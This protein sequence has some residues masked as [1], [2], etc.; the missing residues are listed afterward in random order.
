MV[1]WLY[2]VIPERA[3]CFEFQDFPTVSAFVIIGSSHLGRSEKFS[4]IRRLS[5]RTRAILGVLIILVITIMAVL[6]APPE[7]EANNVTGDLPEMPT[8]TTVNQL[9][10]LSIQQAVDLGGIHVS[11]NRAVLAS[12]FSDDRKRIGTYTLR[13][14]VDTRNPT[15]N[16]LGYP[17]DTNV[18]LI[19]PDGQIVSTKLISVAASLLP[20]QAKSGYFDFPLSQPIE[21]EQLQLQFVG[22][23]NSTIVVPFKR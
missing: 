3:I 4:M 7:G 16:V 21:L 17:F 18:H 6:Y 10:E 19:L 14:H 1:M 23:N 20:Q 5:P 13:V 9:S 12:K 8:V 15:Q 2:H 22:D 11:I